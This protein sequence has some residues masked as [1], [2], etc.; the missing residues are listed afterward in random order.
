MSFF[1]GLSARIGGALSKHPQP[2]AL[3]TVASL[4]L[5][6]CGGNQATT[7]PGA[8]PEAVSTTAG[9]SSAPTQSPSVAESVPTSEAGTT[10]QAEATMPA[11]DAAPSAQGTAAAQPVDRSRPAAM[12]NGDPITFEELDT[13]L[14]RRYAAQIIDQLIIERL[15]AQ[16]AER[17]NITATEEEITAELER[18]RGSLQPGQDFEQAV[19]EQFGGQEAFREQLRLNVLLQKMLAPQIKLTDA[20]LQ[21]Y[22]NENKQQFASPE[23]LHVL[24][25]V[26][27]TREQATAAAAE[28]KKGTALEAVIQKSG[29]KQAG[30]AEQSADLGFVQVQTLSPEIAIAASSLQPDQVS[31]P[32]ELQEGGFAVLKVEARRGGEAPP[33]AQVKDRVRDAAQAQSIQQLAPQFLTDL[34]TKAKVESQFEL[35]EPQAPVTEE[36]PAP[37]VPEETPQG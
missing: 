33:L 9:A 6:A 26:S 14:E 37:P 13:L 3:L 19:T 8:S 10:G 22:Y 7:A 30:R 27:D 35:P 11:E 23:E 20:Q 12:V 32:I 29:S 16:E 4:S 25:V 1:R 2:L 17:Q 24:R 21:Q 5:T 31:E 36:P 28:L 34:R 18:A 15:I